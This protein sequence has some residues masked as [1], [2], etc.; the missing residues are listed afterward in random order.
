MSESPA[1]STGREELGRAE[2]PKRTRQLKFTEQSK[3]G[4]RG[5]GRKKYAALQMVLW[6]LQ[7]KAVKH[8][9]VRKALKARVRTA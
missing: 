7:L 3:G 8:M 1:H 5:T 9:H 4:K 2:S 6:K